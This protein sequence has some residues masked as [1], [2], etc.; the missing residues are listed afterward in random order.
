MIGYGNL[1]CADTVLVG[2]YTLARVDQ[3]DLIETGLRPHVVLATGR[4]LQ[5]EPE[6]MRQVRL[7]VEEWMAHNQVDPNLTWGQATPTRQ[8][9]LSRIETF[10]SQPAGAY[11]YLMSGVQS[12]VYNAYLQDFEVCFNRWVA[13]TAT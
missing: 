7:A 1:A 2:S 13:S 6:Y 10:C 8:I 3:I 9:R 5:L 4:K 12:V 11:V